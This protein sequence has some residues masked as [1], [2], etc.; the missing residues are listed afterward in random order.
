MNSSSPASIDNVF[1]INPLE[2]TGLTT[3]VTKIHSTFSVIG[4]HLWEDAPADVAYLRDLHRHEFKFQVTI[5]VA[6]DD[7]EVEF[8]RVKRGALAWMT[9]RF[10]RNADGEYLFN[11]L[12]CESIGR[13]L[14]DHLQVQWPGRQ[15]YEVSIYE[16]GECGMTMTRTILPSFRNYPPM[17]GAFYVAP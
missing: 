8:H 10:E 3:T 7:R 15:V 9:T 12:S 2:V 4:F 14:I 5:T 6:H 17:G 13:F 11:K 1:T 16:D